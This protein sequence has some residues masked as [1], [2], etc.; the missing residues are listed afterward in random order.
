MSVKVY[1]RL[2]KLTSVPSYIVLNFMLLLNVESM[3]TFD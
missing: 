1:C 3:K 2:I